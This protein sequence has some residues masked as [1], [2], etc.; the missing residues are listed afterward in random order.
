M[1]TARE[2]SA[3]GHHQAWVPIL[4]VSLREVFELMLSSELKA[5]DAAPDGPMGMTSMVGL[6]GQ[7]CGVLSIQCSQQAARLMASKMLS[8]Q[9]EQVGPEMCDAFGEICNMVAGNFKNK[10]SGLG[11]GCVLSVPAVI[12]GNDYSLHSPADFDALEVRLMFEGMSLVSS[13]KVQ[14]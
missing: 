2:V 9:P 14:D 6:A 1:N 13:L 8:I 5:P 7:L 3:A 10:I 12:T 4:E 11:D